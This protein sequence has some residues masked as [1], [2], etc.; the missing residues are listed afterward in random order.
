M[1]DPLPTI[2]AVALNPAFDRT[3]EVPDLA[4][5]GHLR[6]RLVAVQ[7][8]GKAVNVARLLGSLGTPCVLTGFVGEGDGPRFVRSFENAPVRVDLLEVAGRTRENITLVDPARGQ[9]THIRDAG[10]PV[11]PRDLAHLVDALAGLTRPGA[12]VIFSGSLPPGMDA[13]GFADLLAMCRDKGSRVAV[14]TSGP[15]LGAVRRLATA[16]G[17]SPGGEHVLWLIKPNREEL[18]ELAGR[19]VTSD[20]DVRA[21]A[22]PLRGRIS[23]IAVTLGRDGAYLFSRE[24]IWRARLTLTSP[25][26]DHH[27]PDGGRYR[28]AV[29]PARIVKTVGSGDAFLAGFIKARAEGRGPADCL[30]LAV[31]CGTASTFQLRAG[32]VDPDDFAAC[33]AAVDVTQVG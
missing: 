8:A 7:P 15:G 13:A 21:A 18:A 29:D 33:V 31:A 26:L 24:G 9:E 25:S 4:I 1:A 30:R 10:F 28:P 17:P 14:D 27:A 19:P 6:G 23:E 32:Q 16:A 12:I 22:E 20:D 5:G 11:T 3:I 2:I